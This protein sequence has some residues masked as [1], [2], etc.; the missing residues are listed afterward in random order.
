MDT[1][2]NAV[3]LTN[4]LAR[5]KRDWTTQYDDFTDG[6]CHTLAVA[7]YQAM[8]CQGKL[9]ACLRDSFNED[10]L[11]FSTGYSHM[12][13]GD[14]NGVNWDING[15][16]ADTR[17]EDDFDF[18]DTPDEHGLVHEFR[19]VDV[20]YDTYQCWLQDHFGAID[21]GLTAKLTHALRPFLNTALLST[22][23][24]TDPSM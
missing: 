6:D 10:G 24:Q 4:A 21:N 11:L 15:S 7:L 16:Q 14:P 18:T 22:R 8:D 1:F 2:P 3:D 23:V 20:P 19:W 17:W 13:Y 5:I 9:Y 12:V